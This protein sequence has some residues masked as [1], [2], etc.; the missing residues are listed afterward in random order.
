[1]F[2]AALCLMNIVELIM[3][4]LAEFWIVFS[5]VSLLV[6]QMDLLEFG[7]VT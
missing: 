7:I 6:L 1:M 5:Q 4:L 2:G 3:A